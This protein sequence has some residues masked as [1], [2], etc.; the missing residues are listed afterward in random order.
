M[1]GK[2]VTTRRSR[3]S[4]KTVCPLDKIDSV[5]CKS[6]SVDAGEPRQGEEAESGDYDEADAHG[7]GEGPA[8]EAAAVCDLKALVKREYTNSNQQDPLEKW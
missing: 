7:P 1:S 2:T 6:E 5:S 3:V 8:A 4:R